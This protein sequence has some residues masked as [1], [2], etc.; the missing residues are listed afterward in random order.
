MFEN[1]CMSDNAITSLIMSNDVNMN[2][3]TGLTGQNTRCL[4]KVSWRSLK[5]PSKTVHPNCQCRSKTSSLFSI[6]MGVH[7]CPLNSNFLHKL[8]DFYTENVWHLY[9]GG[10]GGHRRRPPPTTGPNS[11]VFPYVSTKKCPCRRLAPPNGKSWIR[12]CYI[13]YFFD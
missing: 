3:I 12:S 5:H 11:F 13:K 6:I 10:S 7:C 8:C 4:H 2:P 1:H 9:S